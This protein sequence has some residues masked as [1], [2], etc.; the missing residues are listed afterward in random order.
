MLSE[1]GA[2]PGLEDLSVGSLPPHLKAG[3]GGLC[4]GSRWGSG[5]G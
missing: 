4:L 3:L 2:P 1:E 5:D